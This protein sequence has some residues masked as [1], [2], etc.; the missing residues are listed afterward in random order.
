M[1][2]RQFRPTLDAELESRIVLNAPQLF[3][4]LPI[5]TTHTYWQVLNNINSAFHS[6]QHSN[7]SEHAFVTL[8]N[9]LITQANRLPFGNQNL[10]PLIPDTINPITLQNT[11][12]IKRD[13]VD[14]LNIYIGSSLQNGDFVFLQS[15]DHHSSDKNFPRNGN[16]P[17]GHNHNNN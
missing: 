5:L 8:E 10:V 12:T 1:R 15:R 6:W 13:V 2:S 17:T 7:G 16:V 4:G 9:R 14:G 3:N 11:A